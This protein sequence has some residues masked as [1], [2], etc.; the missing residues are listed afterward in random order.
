MRNHS[1][2][3]A[4]RRRRRR[5]HLRPRLARRGRPPRRRRRLDRRGHGRARNRPALWQGVGGARSRPRSA[6][7][8]EDAKPAR[9]PLGDGGSA[10]KPGRRHCRRKL[11]RATRLRPRR[12]ASAVADGAARRRSRPVVPA[13]RQRRSREADQRGAAAFR[14]RRFTAI[15]G[16]AGTSDA[17]AWP[18]GLAFAHRQGARRPV[19]P[20][21]DRSA[22]LARHC[23]RFRQGR[24]P[25]C[26]S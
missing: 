21:R 5:F 8:R 20:R 25:T 16:G 4:R 9:N 26:V 13:A 6:G 24:V 18:D 19:W 2:P 23:V 15:L 11:D 1:R 17:V 22:D 7:V 10:E 12:F 14:G 3:S